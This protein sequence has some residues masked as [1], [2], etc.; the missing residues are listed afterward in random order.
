[1]TKKSFLKTIFLFLGFAFGIVFLIYTMAWFSFTKRAELYISQFLASPSITTTSE[2]PKFSGY[3]LVPKAEFKGELKHQSGLVINTPIITYSGF[4]AQKQVQSFEAPQGIKISSSYLDR[5]L[6]FDY[7]YLQIRM[8]SHAPASDRKEDVLAWQKSDTPFIIQQIVLNGG[9]IYA[10]GSGYISLDENL[11]I[12]ANIDARVVGMDFLFDEMEKEQG[13]KTL[14]IARNFFNM[15][16]KVD[17]KTGE[18]YF[19]TTLKIQNR[20]IYFGPMRISGLPELKWR[21]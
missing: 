12:V 8:P 4:P 5:D 15:M 20:G 2:H 10:H 1:M 9:N 6:N 13:K 3:P 11:Q 17:E 14:A 21:D 18:K 19:E 7:A 16:S